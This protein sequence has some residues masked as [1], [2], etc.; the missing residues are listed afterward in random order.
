MR[1]A[2]FQNICSSIK[3]QLKFGEISF[4]IFGTDV[5][6][7]DSNTVVKFHSTYNVQ[8]SWVV[9]NGLTKMSFLNSKY[10]IQIKWG[11][12]NDISCLLDMI[13]CLFLFATMSKR[14]MP[15]FP[16]IQGYD[17]YTK[18]DFK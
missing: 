14:K 17:L 7:Q 5:D 1:C 11:F 16:M 6:S 15:T 8:Y 10:I 13:F 4:K 2:S 18:I 9:Y 3:F 12:G